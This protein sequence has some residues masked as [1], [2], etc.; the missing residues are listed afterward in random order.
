MRAGYLQRPGRNQLGEWQLGEKV[1]GRKAES[2]GDIPQHGSRWH[3]VPGAS[4]LRGA[5]ARS[6]FPFPSLSPLAEGAPEPGTLP[7]AGDA[8]ALLGNDAKITAKRD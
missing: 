7:G 4:V 6:S 3:R 8:S 5:A 2:R 1:R